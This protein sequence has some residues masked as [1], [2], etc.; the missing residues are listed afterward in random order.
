M[1]IFTSVIPLEGHLMP[2]ALSTQWNKLMN[3]VEISSCIDLTPVSIASLS[4]FLAMLTLGK[5]FWNYLK[6]FF[7]NYPVGLAPSV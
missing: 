2:G 4:C 1:N 7:G 5:N 3:D 6:E